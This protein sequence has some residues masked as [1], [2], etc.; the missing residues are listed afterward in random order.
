MPQAIASITAMPKFSLEDGS[1]KSAASRNAASFSRPVSMPAKLVRP[2]SPARAT[3]RRA[4][5][6]ARRAGAAAL[7]RTRAELRAR[8][9]GAALERAATGALERRRRDLDRLAVAL[10]AHDPQRTLER[11]YALVEDGAGDPV[12]SAAEARRRPSLSLRLHDGRV[13]VR[14]EPPVP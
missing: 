8:A 12:T 6:A 11:G 2:S 4:A 10:A 13:P 5:A 1:R 3:H 9:D 7:A 14:P